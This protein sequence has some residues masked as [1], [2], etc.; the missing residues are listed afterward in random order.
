MSWVDCETHGRYYYP[1]RR[2]HCPACPPACPRP[3]RRK[4]AKPT[5]RNLDILR[6]ICDGEGLKAVAKSYGLT[7]ER[8]RQIATDLD[9]QATTLGIRVRREP[10]LIRREVERAKR[11]ASNPACAVCYGPIKTV[12]RAPHGMQHRTCS[13]RCRDLA[14]IARH[15][16][17]PD[18]RESQRQATAKWKIRNA[19]R[20]SPADLRYAERVLAGTSRRYEKRAGV[21]SP[22]VKV[23]LEEVAQLRAANSQQSEEVGA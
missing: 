9:P 16:L 7:C 19:N 4:P 5:E 13:S 18:S 2:L 8:V 10:V 17:F 22:K 12:L 14:V 21:L 15:H 1:T 20:I 11:L 23:A 3:S 6:R